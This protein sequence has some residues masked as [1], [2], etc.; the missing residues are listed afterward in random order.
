[1]T[2]TNIG[3]IQQP[4]CWTMIPVPK[5]EDIK[6]GMTLAGIARNTEGF[7]NAIRGSGNTH[8]HHLKCL[9]AL[10]GIF[11]LQDIADVIKKMPNATTLKNI[12]NTLSI[13]SKTGDVAG[14]AKSMASFLKGVGA[15]SKSA[16]AWTAPL[17]IACIPLEVIGLGLD[18]K[19]LVKTCRFA[20][21]LTQAAVL[22]KQTEDYTEEDYRSGMSVIENQRKK[23]KGFIKA[24]F[25][26]DETQFAHRLMMIEACAKERIASANPDVKKEGKEILKTT[27]ETLSK[28]ISTK[29]W[30]QTLSLIASIV[31]LVAGLILTFT[32]LAP[33]GLALVIGISV[34]SL[35]KKFIYDKRKEKQFNKDI[36]GV[37]H[38]A[39]TEQLQLK[40][41]A[42]Q[43]KPGKVSE[44]TKLIKQIELELASKQQFGKVMEQLKK[45]SQLI[46]A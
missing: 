5:K 38:R 37:Y 16:I 26:K 22:E 35:G 4:D 31:G 28:R 40:A 23:D 10:K 20:S 15:V 12:E 43:H 24:N 7:I 17:G 33:L 2:V 46:A 44:W 30:S 36:E 6:T 41:K 29:K 13:V 25:S 34:F 45:K 14:A 21:K 27:M 9:S 19:A 32:P 42:D 11:S 39:I 18:I 8:L 1:M 3:I